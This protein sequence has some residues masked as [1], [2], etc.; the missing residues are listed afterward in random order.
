[1]ETKLNFKNLC[2]IGDIHGKF[3]ELVYILVQQKKLRETAVIVAGDFGL[4]FHKRGYYEEEYKHIKNR[5]ASSGNC[6]L[7]VRG[8][9]D[10]PEY[11]NPESELFLDYPEFKALPD[12]SRLTWKNREILVIGGATSTDKVWRISHKQPWW[13]TERP[14]QDF[15]KLKLKEDI[16]VSHEA[17]LCVGPVTTRNSDFDVNTY[18]EIIDDRKYLSK[19]L[20][21]TKPRRWYFGHHH[22]STTG[23]WGDTLWTGLDINE[24]IEVRDEIC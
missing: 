11:F 1:M 9:H 19:V 10:D 24:L 17:P 13:D 18:R 6:I 22:C 4:G 15:E 12:Y 3:R 16:I 7:G 23:N 5:L 14:I 8:N 20:V 2:I 21:E